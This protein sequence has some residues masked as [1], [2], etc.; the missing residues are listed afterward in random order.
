M[1]THDAEIIAVIHGRGGNG[2]TTVALGLAKELKES[3]SKKVL[4]LDWDFKDGQ[5]GEL[6]KPRLEYGVEIGYSKALGVDVL[7]VQIAKN[8]PPLEELKLILERLGKLY[9]YIVIDSSATLN[10]NEKLFSFLVSESSKIV[11]VGR[12]FGS[13]SMV[14]IQNYIDTYLKNDLDKTLI[15]LNGTNRLELEELTRGEQYL[16]TALMVPF[17]KKRITSSLKTFL[18]DVEIKEAFQKIALAV[19]QNA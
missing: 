5:V 6:S 14:D 17:S 19:I 9:D 10:H 18:N 4:L 15:V 16:D 13:W 11:L 1:K 2:G 7:P 3:T 12:R 8:D